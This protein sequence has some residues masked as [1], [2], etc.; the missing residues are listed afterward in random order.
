MVTVSFITVTGSG[1]AERANKMS[2]VNVCTQCT[3]SMKLQSVYLK[4]EPFQSFFAHDL[5]EG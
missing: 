1:H 4:A 2:S 5:N 3:R